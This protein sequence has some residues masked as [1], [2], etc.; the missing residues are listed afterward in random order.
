MSYRYIGRLHDLLLD[1]SSRFSDIDA[2]HRQVLAAQRARVKP[3]WWARLLPSFCKRFIKDSGDVLSFM[4]SLDDNQVIHVTAEALGGLIPAHHNFLA[5]HQEHSAVAEGIQ[6]SCASFE[7]ET[8][9][10]SSNQ[11]RMPSAFHESAAATQGFKTSGATDPLHFSLEHTCN[12]VPSADLVEVVVDPPSVVV[13]SHNRRD[14]TQADVFR[15]VAST[16]SPFSVDQAASMR[17]MV[18]AV[19]ARSVQLD[20]KGGSMP[21]T[22]SDFSAAVVAGIPTRTPPNIPASS[23]SK[24]L[25]E[26]DVH[27]ADRF[28]GAHL[29]SSAPALMS[30]SAAPAG[31]HADFVEKIDPK[32][33]RTYWVKLSTKARSWAPPHA[34]HAAARN[35][36]AVTSE[37]STAGGAST[38]LERRMPE[39]NARPSSKSQVNRIVNIELEEVVARSAAPSSM[40]RDKQKSA[41]AQSQFATPDVPTI[42]P[43]APSL[44]S[45]GDLMRR[46]GLADL[47]AAGA[48]YVMK[49]ALSSPR[50]SDSNVKSSTIV[51]VRQNAHIELEKVV[52]HSAAAPTVQEQK[53]SVAVTSELSAA[54]G[55]STTLERRMPESNA[56]PS[57]KLKVN[58]IVNIELEEV[59]ARSAAPSSMQ[60][61]KQKSASAQRQG[62]VKRAPKWTGLPENV[63]ADT[64]DKDQQTKNKQQPVSAQS[65]VVKANETSAQVTQPANVADVST[66]GSL[67]PGVQRPLEPRDGIMHSDEPT[68]FDDD[69]MKLAKRRDAKAAA[70][71]RR[72]MSA[73]GARGP[74]SSHR[75]P[76]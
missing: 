55:A 23:R 70:A 76:E 43:R 75:H 19:N 24:W 25:L 59:V 16:A 32:S 50:I 28:S 17:R 14:A 52:A 63:G 38:T 61:D 56:R 66:S 18:R 12:E 68:A 21:K 60:R 72:L 15:E 57:S 2:I 29:P 10:A 51:Q 54:G 33:G 22:T 46:Q 71:Q 13:A 6:P 4:G 69:D 35:D 37:L 74:N 34:W 36:A 30:A 67:Q 31:V 3:K 44:T 11:Q 45:A 65:S 49:V 39:S 20:G 58:R 27:E 8:V 1:M 73:T 64:V 7:H 53:Q 41:S 48:D 62:H 9:T 42:S 26:P 5:R 40:Q 47:A